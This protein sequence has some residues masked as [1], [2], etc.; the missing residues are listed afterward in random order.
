MEDRKICLM[1]P[2]G[3]NQQNSECKKLYNTNNSVSSIHKLQENKRWKG[4]QEI[5][6]DLRHTNFCNL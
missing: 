4:N 5:K 6:R 1:K 3:C 2:K